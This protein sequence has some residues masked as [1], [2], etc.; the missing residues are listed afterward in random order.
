MNK[1]YK[2]CLLIAVF[3]FSSSVAWAG[4]NYDSANN[5]FL[6]DSI[7]K[8]DGD[9]ILVG[10]ALSGY[11]E[12]DNYISQ[13]ECQV[14]GSDWKEVLSKINA[15]GSTSESTSFFAVSNNLIFP[16]SGRF[17]SGVRNMSKDEFST[18]AISL[19]G[20][21]NLNIKSIGGS[22]LLLIDA[23]RLEMNQNWAI[24]SGL[25]F[26]NNTAPDYNIIVEKTK[27]VNLNI[28]DGDLMGFDSGN[29]IAKASQEINANDIYF[30]NENGR[31][32]DLCVKIILDQG[33]DN[34]S[35]SG[36]WAP[37]QIGDRTT[38]PSNY[39]VY[40]LDAD[41]T[42]SNAMICCRKP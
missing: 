15:N 8:T 22:G 27:A 11:C 39:W 1:I 14:N 4:F 29:L 21:Q 25:S 34:Y 19:L 12:N 24:D 26:T 7:F 36:K 42:A 16:A 30:S 33:D 17:A 10:D 23:N 13:A 20:G 9:Y 5:Y 18:N 3:V 41:S 32:E 2:I 37:D 31:S 28:L 35:L 40:D 38:C 6:I